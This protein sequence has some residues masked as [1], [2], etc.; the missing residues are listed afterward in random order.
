[1]N[2][3]ETLG[4][5]LKRWRQAQDFTQKD[6]AKYTGVSRVAWSAYERD[7]RLPDAKFFMRF[8]DPME[9]AVL[10]LGET[11]KNLIKPTTS[12]E[13]WGA[14]EHPPG[15]SIKIVEREVAARVAAREEASPWGEAALPPDLGRLVGGFAE[16]LVDFEAGHL[17]VDELRKFI[18]A[19]LPR[20]ARKRGRPL[21]P[22]PEPRSD[23]RPT[24]PAPSMPVQDGGET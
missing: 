7:K 13:R 16:R 21:G 1:M 9:L 14:S 23:P 18:E 3:L 22:E 5:R 2:P 19:E 8:K 6:A 15:E 10:L 24:E 4:I 17:E 12:E 20:L 11:A